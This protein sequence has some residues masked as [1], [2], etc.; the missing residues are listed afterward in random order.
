MKLQARVQQRVDE[1]ANPTTR[2]CTGTAM[3]ILSE[4]ATLECRKGQSG[5]L[6]LGLSWADFQISFS[7][8]N[9]ALSLIM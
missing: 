9:S 1:A 3:E 7:T 6:L 8:V 4:I 5:F 2:K